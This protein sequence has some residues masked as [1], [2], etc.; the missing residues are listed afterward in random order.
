MR[1]VRWT[2]PVAVLM[3]LAAP[4]ASRAQAPC[5]GA[6]GAPSGPVVGPPAYVAP[7]P[8]AT[9]YAESV[10]PLYTVPSARVIAPSPLIA[11][12]YGVPARVLVPRNAAAA[13]VP[14]TAVFEAPSPETVPTPYVVPAAAA[15]VRALVPRRAVRYYGY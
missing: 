11:T 10:S 5:V 9:V 4:G 6:G 8:I 12:T 13:P 3:A 7:A 1:F 15:P 14:A 2:G